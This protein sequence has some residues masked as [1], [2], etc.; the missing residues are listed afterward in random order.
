MP[1]ED[2]APSPIADLKRDRPDLFDFA[3]IPDITLN[4]QEQRYRDELWA[5]APPSLKAILASESED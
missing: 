3:D 1:E 2:E 5:A 4:D